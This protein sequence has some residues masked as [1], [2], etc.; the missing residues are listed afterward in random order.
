M[1]NRYQKSN[2]LKGKQERYYWCCC[3]IIKVE[4]EI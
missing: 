4:K 1:E 3:D 2:G